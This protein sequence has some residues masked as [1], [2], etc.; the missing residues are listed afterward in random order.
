[1]SVELVERAKAKVHLQVHLQLESL[2]KLVQ[3]QCK[4]Y[5]NLL[6]LP[7]ELYKDAQ[8]VLSSLQILRSRASDVSVSKP[9]KFPWIWCG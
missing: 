3:R 5:R 6:S 4:L 8:V 1:M 9:D 7:S 2:Q